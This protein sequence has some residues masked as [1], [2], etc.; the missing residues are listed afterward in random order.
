MGPLLRQKG[1]SNIR[2]RP[3]TIAHLHAA[4]EGIL[5]RAVGDAVLKLAAG[6][7]ASMRVRVCMRQV[8]E[9]GVVGAPAVVCAV[10]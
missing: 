4:P 1:L 7:H 2:N 3:H 9:R 10:V 8:A 5:V 6:M